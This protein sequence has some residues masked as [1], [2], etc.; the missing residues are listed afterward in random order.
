MYGKFSI[1]YQF[2]GWFWVSWR[3]I[4][5]SKPA[6]NAPCQ[7]PPTPMFDSRRGWKKTYSLGPSHIAVAFSAQF[8]GQ[9]TVGSSTKSRELRGGPKKGS[10]TK[11]LK[12]SS[13]NCTD[14]LPTWKMKKGDIGM[15]KLD[16][17]NMSIP[18]FGASKRQITH[19]P[20]Q[21]SQSDWSVTWTNAT[22]KVDQNTS[23][24]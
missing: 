1:V 9:R 17:V 24:K 12:S 8:S 21:R 2:L 20:I 11:G 5:D 19:D 22:Y 18:V 23:Y 14:D 7:W 10:E 13:W 16:W 15:Q 4:L 6:S 3:P